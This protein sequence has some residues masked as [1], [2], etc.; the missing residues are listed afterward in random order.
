MKLILAQYLRTLKERNEFDSLLAD[1]LLAMG[2][3]PI[4]KPQTGNRQYGV[5]LAAV[6]T[7]P[8]DGV[9]EL[10][11]L[12]IKQ[13]DIGRNEWDSPKPQSVRPSLNEVLDVYLKTH[14]ESAHESLRKKII[15]TTTG[16]LKQDTQINWDNYTKEYSEKAIFE[17]WGGDKVAILIEKYMLN[18]YIFKAEDRAHLRK[19]LALAGELDYDH[20]DLHRLFIRQLGLTAEGVVEEPNL[21]H[22]E[23]V[24]G[25]RVVNLASQIFARWSEDEGN[26]K[27]SLMAS[28]RAMLWSWHRIQLEDADN[29]QRYYKE[30]GEIWQSYNRVAHRY[31]EKLQPHLYVQ[32]G[33][34]GYC[35]ENA[36]FSLVVFEQIGLLAS[37]G[38]CRIFVASDNKTRQVE[39][40]NAAIIADAL[41]ALIANNPVSG[42]PRLDNNVVDVV[43]GILLLLLTGNVTQARK[44]LA[45]LIKR[46]DYTLKLKRNFPIC[47][48]STDDLVESIVFGSDELNSS[49]MKMSWLLPTLAGW[50][51]ILE[52]H[53]LYD[54]LSK[55]AKE[56]YPEICLQLWH[57]T[58][59]DISTHLYFGDALFRC[60]ESEAPIQLPDTASEYRSRMEALLKSERH[61]VVALSS[62]GLAGILAIDLV[63]C[64]HFR[65]PIA[66][67]FWYQFLGISMEGDITAG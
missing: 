4:S 55:N 17:F 40:D 63:A 29:R 14:V 1:V 49:L 43:L 37:I 59:Q 42:S 22:R 3:A 12:V 44:W 8:E 13:G 6:G 50:S 58:V 26:L 35:R 41:A 51:I 2:Y 11:L 7:A 57:P 47:S 28:E 9:Q 20:K 38:L 18:E 25:L 15:L 65:T 56:S 45:E 60:G 19:S 52:Q 67:M 64:R 30:F 32:E 16:D 54:V 33:L 23:V 34:S 21:P 48:D 31:F 53:D 46:I 36:E 39:F 61:N 66:P 27:H 62:A 24:K 5:D 10:V